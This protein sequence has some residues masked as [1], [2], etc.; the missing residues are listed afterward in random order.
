[1][2]SMLQE[3]HTLVSV[4]HV[5]YKVVRLLGSGGQGEVYE[6]LCDNKRFA[7]K[8][9]HHHMATSNQ[10]AILDKLIESQKPDSRFLWPIDI[11]EDKKSFGYVMELRQDQYKSIVDLMKRRAE[12]TFYALCT[13][14]YNLAD[15]FQKLHSKGYSYQDISFG[16]T[17]FNPENG[18]IIIC[19]NDNVTI[20]GKTSSNIQG[21]LGFM[22]PEIVTGKRD[23][24]TATDLFS[25]AILLFYMFMLHHPLEGKKEADIKCFDIA[26]KHKIYGQKPV[27]IW[28][29]HNDSNRPVMGYQDNAIIYWKIYPEFV[30][31]LF[32]RAFTEGMHH[33][34]KRIVENQWKR[35]FIQLRD[36]IIQCQKCGAENFYDALKYDQGKEHICWSCAS[37][38]HLPPRLVISSFSI[39]L[40][41][42]TKIYKH[43]LNN[44]FD[45]KT[46]IAQVSRHPNDP[47]KWGLKNVSKDNW[48]LTKPDGS[49]VLIEP[50]RNVPLISGMK[51]NING[52]IAQLQDN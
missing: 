47:N 40:N 1:M 24:S 3:G 32:I 8:W 30:K 45:L 16:N 10:R 25:L 49:I 18:D 27:F 17:F 5:A 42:N 7:L 46:E 13:A 35:A 11:I 52:I 33:P 28:D 15:C 51:I 39:M 48:S 41:Q 6:V 2:I 22:A 20:N 14:G 38:I 36:S 43:H 23:P 37:A 26:A 12:P 4:N 29:P 44:D 34:N 9:Y 21:T 19:D 31:D 50:G